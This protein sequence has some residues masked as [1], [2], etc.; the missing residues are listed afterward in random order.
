VGKVKKFVDE[1]AT[2]PKM[3]A[4]VDSL[5][6]TACR[7]LCLNKPIEAHQKERLARRGWEAFCDFEVS[8]Q[9]GKIRVLDEDGNS[10]VA[11]NAALPTWMELLK[12]DI[13][14]L[15]QGRLLGFPPQLVPVLRNILHAPAGAE[16]LDI[17]EAV[18]REFEVPPSSPLPK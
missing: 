8:R 1:M 3:R 6:V 15:L 11:P 14:Q 13:S 10:K 16:K 5:V 4:W 7:D 17:S 12:G 9:E 2:Y 18:R